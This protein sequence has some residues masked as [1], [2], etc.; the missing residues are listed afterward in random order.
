MSVNINLKPTTPTAPSSPPLLNYQSSQSPPKV[1]L[2]FKSS[3]FVSKLL[4]A[5]PPYLYNIP[6]IPQNF[7]FSEM[8]KSFVHA[9]NHHNLGKTGYQDQ[10]PHIGGKKG[11]KRLWQDVSTTT[12]SNNTNYLSPK[13]NCLTEDVKKVEPLEL[14]KNS[15]KQTTGGGNHAF[16]KLL[17]KPRVDFLGH[18]GD[19]KQETQGQNFDQSYPMMPPPIPGPLPGGTHN[20]LQGSSPGV[21]QVIPGFNSGLDAELNKLSPF[22]NYWNNQQNSL[23]LQNQLQNSGF[24]PLHFFIDL[25]VSGHIYDKKLCTEAVNANEPLNLQKSNIGSNEIHSNGEMNEENNN[26]IDGKCVKSETDEKKVIKTEQEQT[27]KKE[28]DENQVQNARN[29]NLSSAFKFPNNNNNNNNDEIDNQNVNRRMKGNMKS[30]TNYGMNY[31]LNNLP[32]IYK[33]FNEQT[34]VHE[35]MDHEYGNNFEE[36]ATKNLKYLKSYHN[37]LRCD[38]NVYTFQ[39]NYEHFSKVIGEQQ[40]SN[41]NKT[42]QESIEED[43]EKT[44]EN[45]LS[46]VHTDIADVGKDS[47]D[48]DANYGDMRNDF[49]DVENSESDLDDNGNSEDEFHTRR[50]PCE[51]AR[52]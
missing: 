21:N 37:N 4:A 13:H 26:E 28:N 14:T 5:T 33:N 6:L 46:H 49:V 19:L 36:A 35:D 7:F 8:L 24:D 20:G 31:I 27:N 41:S 10:S 50:D 43:Q 2:N 30:K 25:R 17:K 39:N 9:R 22:W 42:N 29:E 18:K 44:D 11:R 3:E 52:E 48:D 15:N 51:T 16:K 32:K 12:N 45:K 40:Q 34:A 1:P 47:S 38:K 23:N